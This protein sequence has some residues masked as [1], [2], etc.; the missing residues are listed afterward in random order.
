MIAFCM[1]GREFRDQ[2]AASKNNASVLTRSARCFIGPS[3]GQVDEPELLRTERADAPPNDLLWIVAWN[4][5]L[6]NA[7]L[8][9][10]PRTS[11]GATDLAHSQVHF[12]SAP[13]L[14]LSFS[15]SPCAGSQSGPDDGKD[16]TPAPS[17]SGS[18]RPV[19]PDL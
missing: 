8:S 17:C 12:A 19:K 6:S 7:G 14:P 2:R 18:E 11:L 13:S 1:C 16:D 5:R 10:K 9:N 3:L 4:P 15:H